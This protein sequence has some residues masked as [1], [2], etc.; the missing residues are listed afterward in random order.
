[1]QKFGWILFGVGSVLVVLTGFVGLDTGIR[2]MPNVANL[3]GVLAGIG[4]MISGSVFAAV[5]QLIEGQTIKDHIS[6]LK[7]DSAKNIK[8]AENVGVENSFWDTLH[9]G[10]VKTHRGYEVHKR[11]GKFFIANV[12]G[13]FSSL[14]EAEKHIDSLV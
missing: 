11:D 12:D 5:G 13:S 6:Q 10:V 1:M 9:N 8:A 4:M 2:G 7:T 14:S 3:A